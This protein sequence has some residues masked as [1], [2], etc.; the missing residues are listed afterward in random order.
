MT[1]VSVILHV[2]GVI[3]GIADVA[4]VRMFG[5]CAVTASLSGTLLGPQFMPVRVLMHPMVSGPVHK[6][7]L[8]IVKWLAG[9]DAWHHS[10]V[11]C[12]SP[13]KVHI[14]IE[15]HFGGA[16]APTMK[17][18]QISVSITC[19]SSFDACLNILVEVQRPATVA[20]G[21]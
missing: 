4:A 20:R 1:S 11:T 17:L 19:G 14:A 3:S 12:M 21:T 6:V 2:D 8:Q 18:S 9:N 15:Y 10:T 16:V 5:E 7:G 13:R